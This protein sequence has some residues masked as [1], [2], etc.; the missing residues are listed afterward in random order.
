VET[1][2]HYLSFASEEIRDGATEFKCCPPIRDAAN[3]DGLWRGLAA[4]DIDF[5]VTDHSPC[6]PEL[7]AREA[8][9][10]GEA[11][12]GI[13]SLQVG[14]PAVWTT[15]RARGHDLADVVR[16]MATGPA[17]RI[18]LTDRGRVAVGAVADLCVFAP[19]EVLEVDPA[20]LHH[21][22][23]VTPW[24]GR[25]LTGTVRQTWLHGVPVDLG[26]PPRGRLLRREER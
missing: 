25:T 17:E 7:K 9:D 10:F 22:N 11:W 6:T 18:G 26:A 20:G 23:P 24:A 13:A 1:C 12:G 2:P 21:K 15:A 3:R 19:D 16:W 5:V 4:G 14:L 8:G